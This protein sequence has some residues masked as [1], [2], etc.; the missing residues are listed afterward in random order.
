MI[1]LGP[2][3]ESVLAVFNDGE[4]IDAVLVAGT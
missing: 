3:S 4:I 2:K 1:Y